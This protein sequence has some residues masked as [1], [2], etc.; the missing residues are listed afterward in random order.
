MFSRLNLFQRTQFARVM[1]DHP[2]AC[3]DVGARGGFEKDLEPIAF[4]VDAYGFEPERD[5]FDRLQDNSGPW[6]SLRFADYGLSKDGGTQTLH[7][8]VAAESASLMQHDPALGQALNKPRFFQLDH[9]LEVETRTLDEALDDLEVDTPAYLKLDIEG[10]ELPVLKSGP[11]ALESLF[12]IKTEIS[13]VPLRLNQPLAHDVAGF[14]REQG[15]LLMDLVDSHRWRRHG[16]TQHPFVSRSA[17]PYSRGQLIH[18]DYLFFR[19]PKKIGGTDAALQAAFL[20]MNHGYF[21]F[22]ETL[23]LREDVAGH[24]RDRYD[25]D[26]AR[27]LAGA[28][29]VYGRNVWA[30]GLW[31]RLRG[32][33]PYLRTLPNVFR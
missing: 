21:D 31:Q 23:L 20:A 29:A 33:S 3:L 12:A 2:M 11:R 9:T 7:I 6:R 5:A 26:A 17:I 22:A 18:G 8:P 14:M 4:A 24:L 16:W 28:S 1:A 15:F 13:F 32:I 25:V 27:A 10:P 19:E 30:G